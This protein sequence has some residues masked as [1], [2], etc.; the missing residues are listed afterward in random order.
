MTLRFTE[1][2]YRSEENDPS[3]VIPVF[4]ERTNEFGSASRL[5][6]DITIAVIPVSYTSINGSLYLPEDFPAVENFDP[7]A[8][9][10]A[11]S[12]CHC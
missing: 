1:A 5:A 4:V 6:T 10:I 2:D 9:T 11:K 3:G 12:E 7:R 8:P